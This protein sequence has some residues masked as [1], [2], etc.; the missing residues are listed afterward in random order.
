MFKAESIMRIFRAS[1]L[2]LIVLVSVTLLAS[3][4]SRALGANPIQLENAKPG[5]TGW[6]LTNPAT[7]REIE[8]YASLT[9]VNRGG[10]ISLYVNTSA[11]TYTIE[12][13]RMGWYAAAGARRVVSAI[14]RT[15]VKQVIPVPDRVTGLVE[16]NWSNPYVLAIPNT[17]D[18]T[19]WCSGVY[20]AKLTTSA[21]KQS[22]IIFVVR[23]DA[24]PSSFL[25]QASFTTYQAYNPWGGNPSTLGTA[26]MARPRSKSRSIVPTR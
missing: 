25:Q 15:G 17:A 1:S 22:Y 5:T 26:P 4:P 11:A 14:T 16:C 20:L 7:N 10:Q 23:D 13:F 18:S 12:V 24:R 3:L 19:D 2:A 6:N 9:S 21:G 8:G